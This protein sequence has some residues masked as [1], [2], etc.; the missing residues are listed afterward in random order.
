[1]CLASGGQDTDIVIVDIVA[2][3]GKCR[4]TGHS[5]PITD[6]CFYEKSSYANNNN[7]II[8]SS[9]DKQ[10]KIWNIGTQCCFRTIVDYTTEVWGIALLR[11]GDFLVTGCRDSNIN[12]YRLIPNNFD[13]S[14]IGDTAVEGTIIEDQ[15]HL[16]LRCNLVG[17]I[18]RADTRGRICTLVS[19]S[20]GRV[21]VF[22][23]TKSKIIESFL[24]YSDEEAQRRCKKRLKK[25]ASEA[26]NVSNVSLTD[27]ISRL[28]AISIKTKLKSIDVLI[29]VGDNLRI[30]GTFDNNSIRV[31]ALNIME[32]KSEPE[33]LRSLQS[34]GHQFEVRTVC[35]S[36]DALVVASADGDSVKLWNRESMRSVQTI[37][38]TGYALCCCFAPGDRH[39]LI[40]RMDGVLLIADIVSGEILEEILAHQ[41]ELWSMAS[42]SNGS[43]IVTAGGDA[44]VKFWSFELI[45]FQQQNDGT[46]LNSNNR[47]VL[48]LLHKNT[49]KLEETVQCVGVSQN[50]KFLAVGLLDSTVKLFFMDTLKFY[51]ALYGHKLSVLSLDISDDSSKIVTG[52]ADRNVKI[53]GMDFGDCHKSLF[54]HDDSVMCVKFIPKTHLF[55]SCGKDGKIKQWDADTFAQI[56]TVSSHLGQAY[57]LDVSKSGYYIV[58]SG[59]D[60]AI[61]L[62]ERSDEP[63]VLE[64]MQETEREEIEQQKL[65]TGNEEPIMPGMVTPL[66]LPSRKTV[67]AEQAVE[68]LMDALE[69]LIN[70]KDIEK[71]EPIPLLMRAHNVTTPIDLI[72]AIISRIK[73]N[74]LEE[75]LLLLPFTSVC[76]LLKALPEIIVKRTDQTE[77]ICKVI[78]FLFRIHRKPIVGNQTLLPF[79]QQMTTDLEDTV[80]EQRDII[81][82]NLFALKFLQNDIERDE[83]ENGAELF[84]DAYKAKKKRD[85]KMKSRQLKKKISIQIVA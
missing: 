66:N 45:D 57:C 71:G 10:V 15:I 67:A 36:S 19:D 23:G 58:S 69:I 30:V 49:L 27:E 72:I 13:E 84:S 50:G 43:G 56:Q 17:T 42:L 35:F 39:V 79:I 75:S 41:K 64:D 29:G 22:H 48:S 60:R 82:K 26:V 55:W 12:V 85:Q 1:M 32:K 61:R 9:V 73:T 51:L 46:D 77:L 33:L 5:G 44:T 53:W 81:G 59:S 11:G 21:L 24:F 3:V 37:S 6:T 16:P 25:N 2:S 7:I 38:G 14:L 83:L 74:D 40:G 68:L 78:T 70:F 34:Q 65:A 63:I 80:N 54:A 47:K 18:K 52:S 20:S 76:Q 8:S 28:P 62:F 31:F 4:L